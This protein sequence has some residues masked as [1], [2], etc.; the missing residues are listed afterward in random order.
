MR[1][2]TLKILLF[3]DTRSFTC[4]LSVRAISH[5]QHVTFLLDLHFDVWSSFGY[6]SRPFYF[7]QMSLHTPSR[8]RK[9]PDIR[10]PGVMGP[11][12]DGGLLAAVQSTGKQKQPVSHVVDWIEYWKDTMAIPDLWTLMTDFL[13]EDDIHSLI[14]ADVGSRSVRLFHEIDHS[15]QWQSAQDDI[16]VQST[17]NPS[18]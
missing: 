10:I 4:L 3:V 16:K 8:K 9:T 17:T 7:V 18:A 12:M 2:C 6:T 15:Q 5:G 13:T 1:I 11:C 14:C